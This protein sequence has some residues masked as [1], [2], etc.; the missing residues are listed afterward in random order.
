[1]KTIVTNLN[2][3]LLFFIV[4]LM[5]SSWVQG[6]DLMD[7]YADVYPTYDFKMQ[8]IKENG[9]QLLTVWYNE[10]ERKEEDESGVIVGEPIRN[11]RSE[12]H[13]FPDGRIQKSTFYNENNDRLKAYQYYHKG[14]QVAVIDELRF[15]TSQNEEILYSYRYVYKG[16]V[17]MQK[18]KLHIKDKSFR[19]M[20][21][22]TF[23]AKNRLT[24]EKITMHGRA[25]K[26][27]TIQVVEEREQ[28][29][30]ISYATKSKT[31][32]IYTTMH[33]L[34]TSKRSQCTETGQL[35]NTRI[36][37]KD[38]QVVEDIGYVYEDGVLAEEIHRIWDGTQL[39]EGRKIYYQYDA[40]GLITQKIIEEG[41][42]Q[43]VY[44]FQYSKDY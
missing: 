6:Q 44:E 43:F 28:L 8:A 22:Y 20:H 33:D 40:S 7:T 29:N 30:L 3:I 37:N 2:F 12:M 9:Y 41:K 35:I 31:E 14:K 4:G 32:R 39:V 1:M 38:H 23:D 26:I 10:Y 19:L 17:P 24:R 27:E 5:N 16:Q 34:I 25:K 36:K 15:D 42:Q 13:L 11:Y 18:V 21:D